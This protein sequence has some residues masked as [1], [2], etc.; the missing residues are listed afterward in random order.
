MSGIRVSD[1]SRGSAIVS[2]F[3]KDKGA[4]CALLRDRVARDRTAN[5]ALSDPN[6]ILRITGNVHVVH[7]LLRP[8]FCA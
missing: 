3:E 1:S 5:G 2:V 7:V 8:V 4:T 6:S